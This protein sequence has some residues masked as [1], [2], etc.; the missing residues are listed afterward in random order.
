MKRVSSS[1]T[2]A[3]M[4]DLWPDSNNSW[5]GES[6]ATGNDWTGKNGIQHGAKAPQRRTPLCSVQ[7]NAEGGER[8]GAGEGVRKHVAAGSGDQAGQAATDMANGPG[9]S[10]GRNHCGSPAL[11][12]A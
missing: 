11:C 8:A 12:R 3:S 9:G 6:Y 5:E 4:P 1:A 2:A 10:R 7:Q